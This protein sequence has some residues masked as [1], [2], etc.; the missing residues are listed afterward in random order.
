MAEEQERGESEEA[1]AT[2]AWLTPFTDA[3]ADEDELARVGALF[4]TAFTA[5]P[6]G[7][8]IVRQGGEI[9]L[10]NDA[11][12]SMTGYTSD[13][14]T[15][16]RID[17]LIESG[18]RN[19]HARDYE[20]LSTG[21]EAFSTTQ[22]RLTHADGSTIWTQL[23]ISHDGNSPPVSF[24]YQ[25]QDLSEPRELEGRLEYLLDHDYLTGLFN[26]HRFQQELDR[27]LAR[28][29]RFAQGGA[30]LMM[31][32]DGFKAVN[33]RFGHAVG[34][35]LLRSL[36]AAMRGR[37]RVTDVVARL[38]GDEFALLLPSVDREQAEHVASTMLGLVRGHVSA[39]G[40]ER[41]AVT[42]SIG[43]A[44]FDHLTD[45]ELMALADAAMYA[46]KQGGR[47][48]YVVFTSGDEPAHSL[49]VKEANDLRQALKNDQFVLY[50]QP[51]WDLAAQRVDH[52]E[53]LIRMQ[54]EGATDLIEPNSF[55]YA[56]ERFGLI[57]AID[58]WVVSQA[59]ALIEEEDRAGRGTTLSVNLSG[60]SI[61][62]PALSAHIDRTLDESGIDP[63]RLV[64][65]LTET[66]AIGNFQAALTLTS[67]L[68][69]RG[70]QFA[71]DDFGAGFA[72]FYYLKNLPFDYIKIDG[73]FVRG[74]SDSP[75]DQL[76][77][78][79]IVT[80]ARGMGKKTV[81]EFVADQQTSDLL[82]EEG[83]DYAQG[84]H[85]ARP[86]PVGEVLAANA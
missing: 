36:S 5:S 49:R 41:A 40:K 15:A 68:H 47:D 8:A 51:I 45:V 59:V 60:R 25:V 69:E 48:R 83:V 61:G 22:V 16:R 79:A 81:A 46:A 11:L 37:S 86:R 14:L 50:C 19:L 4:R 39:L 6:V 58:C 76:I 31:D 80:I 70:C 27:E 57:T 84:Y 18:D 65:E 9:V 26:R 34:D 44:L 1:R 78:G 10:V 30:V 33:D 35:E 73:D 85:I 71:L 7:M 21:S 29:Q 66:A 28:Q 12:A 38:S 20:S 82:R 67:R 23:T 24:V 52:Y 13:Q 75:T 64:F 2:T 72:S 74:L 55:L 43:V 54:A 77:V 42:A 56:A 53:L 3:M 17:E 62:D 32:L 63:S